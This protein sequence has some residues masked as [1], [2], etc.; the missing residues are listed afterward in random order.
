MGE[1]NNMADNNFTKK[2]ILLSLL[3]LSQG[4]P[5]GFQATAFPLYLRTQGISLAAIGFAGALA[6]P[7]LLKPFWAPLVDRYWNEEFGKRKSWI[8]PLQVLLFLSILSAS[9]IPAGSDLSLLMV[10]VFMMNVFA[11]TQDIAVDGLAVDILSTHELG[12]GNA[13]QV[14]GYKTGMLLSGGLLVWFSS[15]TGWQGFFIAMAAVSIMPLP[16][17]LLYREGKAH[18]NHSGSRDAKSFREIITIAI[19]AFRLPGARW[20]LLF[21]ATYKIGEYMIDAMFKPFLIDSGFS[22][23]DIG[24]WVGTWGMAASL[25]G[26]LAG[27]YMASKISILRA[28]FITVFL[29]IIP[30]VMEFGLTIVIPAS[31]AVIATTVAEHFFGGMLTTAMFAFM[32]SRVDKRIGATHYTIIAAI[33]V[34]GKSPGTWASGLLAE[35]MGYTGLFAAGVILSSIILFIFPMLKRGEVEA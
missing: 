4:L 28:L 23:S 21:V 29:R 22:A 12:T 24:L 5:F 11:A 3:Y 19:E 33:E 26:S 9:M 32:M 30:L 16:F 8:V 6:V 10:S 34:L 25:V 14:V 2:M 7:W 17:I 35:R 27:G 13:A 18:K 15:Y 20:F 31:S 1:T